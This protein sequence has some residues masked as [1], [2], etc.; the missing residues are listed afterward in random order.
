MTRATGRV[1]GIQPRLWRAQARRLAE[2]SGLRCSGQYE[3]VVA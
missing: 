1:D 2:P 3:P